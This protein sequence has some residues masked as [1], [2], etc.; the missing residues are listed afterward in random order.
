MKKKISVII[1]TLNAE[2]EIGSLIE[3][4]FSQTLLPDEI[5]V[6]DSSSSDATKE[7]VAKYPAV[8][9]TTIAREDF[10]HGGT[11]DTALRQSSGDIV[12]FTT[13]DAVPADNLFI[14]KLVNPII[15]DSSIAIVSGRQLPKEDA[16]RSEQLV[17]IYN[18]PDR[19]FTRT[20]EDI[21]R[22]GLKTFFTSDVCAAYNRKVY[23][24]LGGFSATDTNED[25]LMAAKAINAGWKVAYA[26]DAMVYHSHNLN[27]KQQYLRNKAI[28]CFLESNALI[29]NGVSETAEGARMASNI[30]GNLLSEKEFKELLFFSFDCLAR[31]L[32][33]RAGRKKARAQIKQ[34][35]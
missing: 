11:R 3:S 6:I 27:F 14:E 32:G 28:G 20:Q 31:Y 4:L 25:M 17:R 15:E 30:A 8:S 24:D 35:K 7:I 5:I 1:P 26:A 18:Y 13:Q 12:C 2:K 34:L 21:P 16:R 29:L 33:N 23:L 10:N 9:F 19:S 22:L